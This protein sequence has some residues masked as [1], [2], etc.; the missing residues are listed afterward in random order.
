MPVVQHFPPANNSRL[1]RSAGAIWSRGMKLTG[2]ALRV[3]ASCCCALLVVGLFTQS[4]RSL[5]AEKKPVRIGVEYNAPPLSFPG[6]TSDQWQG[7]TVELLREISRAEG[8]EFELVPESWLFLTNEF[9]AGRLDALANVMITEERR[10]SMDFSVGHASVH[11]V[12]YHRP[13]TPPYERTAQFAGKTIAMLTGSRAHM[14]AVAHGGWGA[15]IVLFPSFRETLEAVK[16]GDCD[17]SLLMRRMT[18]EQPDEMGLVRSFV[19]DITYQYHIAVQRGDRATLER[20]NEGLATVRHNG[21]FDRLYDRW[22]GPIEPHPI[23]LADL[24]PYFWPLTGVCLVLAGIFLWQQRIIGER[25]RAAIAATTLAEAREALLRS[26]ERFRLATEATSDGLW[27]WDIATDKCYFSPAYYQM[28][29]YETG[30]FPMSGQ[31]WAALVHPDDIAPARSVIQACINHRGE[32]FEVE[33]RMK[34]KDGTWQWIMGRGTA[35]RRDDQG[36]ARRLIGTHVDINRRKSDET[37]LREKNAELNAALAKVRTLSGLLPICSGCKRIRD[38]KNYW[39]Q[40]E[41]Y[42]S[43]H[44]EAHFTH[45]LCPTCIPKY[46]PAIDLTKLDRMREERSKITS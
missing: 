29:G 3:A 46:F 25:R 42:I 17:C 40:V 23:R 45:S 39:H 30:E 19:N 34:A 21:T 20:I 24:R 44:S 37:A 8:I 5:A 2:H 13:G 1:L 15:R 4:S 7:F 35:V 43:E 10:P 31:S 9:R 28:L 26:E 38:D 11:A 18:A 6:P 32:S 16:R 14:D 36:R 22:I 41:G 27:D 33:F 12:S